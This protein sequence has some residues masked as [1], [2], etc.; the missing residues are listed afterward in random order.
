MGNEAKEGQQ[1]GDDEI[2]LNGV[3]EKEVEKSRQS[4]RKK[5]VGAGGQHKVEENMYKWHGMENEKEAG[6][7]G[8]G[9]DDLKSRW[10]TK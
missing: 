4:E 1:E 2:K 8:K 9:K 3:G 7:R 6:K 10:W 5:S